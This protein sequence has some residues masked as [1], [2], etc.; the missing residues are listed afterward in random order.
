MATKPFW[1]TKTLDEL[2][3]EEWESLC[4]GCGRCCLR[5]FE[6]Y[7]TGEIAYTQVACWLLDGDSCRCRNYSERLSL[8]PDC[9][10]LKRASRDQ[11]KWMPSTCA[12]RLVDAGKPLPVWHPLVSGS[13]QSV[14]AAGIS[15]RGRC[16][17]EAFVHEDEIESL[18]IDWITAKD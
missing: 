13:G 12:Y 10:G 14:H 16:V 18:I 1:E 17:S 9:I 8:V 3:A 7:D 6:N 15:V 2:T 11:L 5:K 4:D